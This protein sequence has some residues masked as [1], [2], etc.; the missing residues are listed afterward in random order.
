MYLFT[1]EK[2]KEIIDE[3]NR[4][5]RVIQFCLDDY[6]MKRNFMDRELADIITQ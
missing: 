2:S 4:S 1:N 3:L 5:Y 6:Y